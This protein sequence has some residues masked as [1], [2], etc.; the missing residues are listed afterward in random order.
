MN[1]V[2]MIV[3]MAFAAVFQCQLPGWAFLGGARVPLLTGVVLYYAFLHGRGT[4]LIA[5]MAAGLLHDSLSDMPLGCSSLVF[6]LLG[7]LM[8]TFR[9]TLFTESAL[10]WAFF[11]AVGAAAFSALTGVVLLEADL[12]ADSFW[13]VGWKVAGTALL[14]AVS[15]PVVFAAGLRMDRL[16]GNI[17]PRT[18][19]VDDAIRFI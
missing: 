3:M 1:L 13:S 11:G 7:L 18:E 6:S 8:A 5:A 4:L 10:T 9:E 2:V 19:T 15:A 16:V 12:I 17:A 14:G